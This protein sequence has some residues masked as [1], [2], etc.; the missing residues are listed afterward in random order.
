M[1]I[2]EQVDAAL[3]KETKLAIADRHVQ[4]FT[5]LL[6]SKA[7]HVR[8][9]EC[10]AYLRIWSQAVKDLNEDQELSSE[11]RGELCD[12]IFS[13]SYD[14]FLSAEEADKMAQIL[15]DESDEE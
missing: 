1:S 13:G 8:V 14:Q 15:G 2:K 6:E 9:S 12:A 7:T 4:N 3:T 10:E 11:A 5:A